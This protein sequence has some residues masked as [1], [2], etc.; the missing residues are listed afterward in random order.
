MQAPLQSQAF[1]CSVSLL[2]CR[3]HIR[4]PKQACAYPET[5]PP[6]D[7]F[8]RLLRG[9]VRP[10]RASKSN[11]AL[12]KQAAAAGPTPGPARPQPVPAAPLEHPM[13]CTSSQLKSDQRVDSVDYNQTAT[14]PP[15]PVPPVRPAA[16]SQPAATPQR[17]QGS[18]AEQSSSPV[19]PFRAAQAEQKDDSA[20]GDEE[21]ELETLPPPGFEKLSTQDRGKTNS[22][23][24]LNR[25][26]GFE[27]VMARQQK[28]RASSGHGLMPLVVSQPAR[29]HRAARQRCP[30]CSTCIC[31]LSAVGRNCSHT[32][33]DCCTLQCTL[34]AVQWP[35]ALQALLAYPACA[36][37]AAAHC[38]QSAVKVA[39]TAARHKGTGP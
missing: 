12:S 6:L 26:Y 9:K 30:V 32:W 27:S 22:L 17:Q 37:A 28:V 4:L 14:S 3:L 38:R 5:P 20:F 31:L 36:C 7:R 11:Q 19:S 23:G 1:T 21:V 33:G 29:A 24:E 2:Q 8:K 35:A 25:Q 15:E 39:V 10:E 34:T 16:P 18:A 13:G